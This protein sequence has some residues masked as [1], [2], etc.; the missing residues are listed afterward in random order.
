MGWRLLRASSPLPSLSYNAVLLERTGRDGAKA[1][2]STRSV[3]TLTFT[4]ETTGAGQEA[5]FALFSKPTVTITK[6]DRPGVSATASLVSTAVEAY[7]PAH[8]R[9]QHSFMVELRQAAWR[10]TVTNSTLQAA[11]TAGAQINVFAGLSAPV[12]DALVRVRGPI[13]NPTVTD[14]G[15]SFFKIEGSIPASTFVRFDSATGRAWQTTTDTWSGGTEVSGIVDF[16]GPRGLF[17]IT[18][19]FV[20]PTERIGTI[21]MTQTSQSSGAAFQVRGQAAHLL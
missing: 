2:P 5:L 4:V 15:G 19:S 1:L 13:T 6:D 9:Y 3:V 14:S 7:H 12:Q 8:D 21:T 11:A 20:N 16:G 17:E 18:P 10:G